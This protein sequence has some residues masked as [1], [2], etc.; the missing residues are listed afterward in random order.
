M[1]EI[2]SSALDLNDRIGDGRALFLVL[3][4]T[5]GLSFPNVEIQV[6]GRVK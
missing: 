5:P 3:L 1:Y 4:C 2:S 6:S